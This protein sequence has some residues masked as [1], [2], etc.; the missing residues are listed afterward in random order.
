M[1]KSFKL[2][3]AAAAVAAFTFS[4]CSKEETFTNAGSASATPQGSSV[5]VSQAEHEFLNYGSTEDENYTGDY[6]TDEAGL[7]DAYQV[8]AGTADELFSAKRDGNAAGI[9]KC[10][11]GLGLDTPQ[12]QQIKRIFAAYEDCKS[13]AIRTHIAGLRNLIERRNAAMRKLLADRKSDSITQ[14]EFVSRVKS[15]N[16]RFKRARFEL[17]EKSKDAISACYKDM[18]NR[19]NGVLTDRQWNA[20]VACYRK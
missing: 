11:S 1:K 3:F 9:R 12:L 5:L 15:M 17:A 4:S 2:W 7:P 19:L 14:R 8:T 13:D 20:F 10:L 16:I 18:L 6:A